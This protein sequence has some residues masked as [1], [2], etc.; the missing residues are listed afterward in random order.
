MPDPASAPR[1]AMRRVVVTGMGVVSA[2]GLDAKSH[3]AALEEGV[4]GI[5]PLDIPDLD[6]LAIKVGAQIKG[7]DGE[8][9]FSRS[10][11]ALYDPITQYALTAA[12]EAMA[13][14]GVEVSEALGLRAAVVMGTALPGMATIDANYRDVF[15]EGK[16]RVHPFIVPRLMV[17]APTSHISMTY[18]LKGPSW[19]VST[20]CSSAN[21]AIGQAFHLVRSGGADIAVTGGVEAPLAFGAMKAWE[22]LRVMTKDVC[23]PFSKGRTGM[24]LGEGSAVFV[25]ETLEAAQARGAQILAEIVGFGMSSDAGDIV[26]PSQDGAARAIAGA[27]ADAGM[28]PDEVGY[29]N[30]HGTGTAANDRTECAALRQVFGAHADALHVSSTKSMH[31]HALGGAGALELVAAIHALRSGVIPP[32]INYLEP[33]PDCD[34]DVTPN[35]AREA[36]VSAA[37]SDSFAFGGLNA[38]IAARRFEG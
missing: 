38:V 17:S 18:G 7:F 37:I 31:G 21:H 6:R 5:G 32:T 16:N 33:D 12:A 8:A 10:Q 23:R 35:V 36:K 24:A 14:S 25:L 9:R 15:Q 34:L 29:V 20:A 28:A 22:G 11:I 4:C 30:A 1:P 26:Q 2:L 27:L 13:Q 19:S 3:C